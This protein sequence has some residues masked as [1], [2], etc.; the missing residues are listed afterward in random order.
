[1]VVGIDAHCASFESLDPPSFIYVMTERIND[2]HRPESWKRIT[3]IM[4][5]HAGH[6]NKET[7]FAAQCSL[8]TVTTI[9]HEL[10]NC[11]GCYMVVARRKQHSRRSDCACAAEFL[12]NLLK[13]VLEESG[14]GI[15]ALSR[16]LNVSDSTMKLALSEDS[17][18]YSYKHHRC[19]LLTE[20]ARENHLTKWKKLLSKVKHPA[21]PQIIW[22]FSDDNFFLGQRHNMQNNR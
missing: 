19:Q 8:N 21:E 10:E 17:C 15:R 22:F 1:M 20:K 4:M 18:Y 11:V 5:I 16:D 3:C 7:I 13:K 9:R 6:Q 14:I 12:K 2:C